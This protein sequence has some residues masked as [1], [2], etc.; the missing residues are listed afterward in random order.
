MTQ[1]ERDWEQGAF[2]RAYAAFRDAALTQ[3]DDLALQRRYAEVSE[4]LNQFEEARRVSE[5]LWARGEA[6]RALLQ[7]R[8]RLSEET[9]PALQRAE[10]LSWLEALPEGWEK[11]AL[12]A[13]V[14]FSTGDFAG[15][16]ELFVRLSQEAPPEE[17]AA[18]ALS[19]AMTF[20][21]S[22]DWAGGLAWL[23]TRAASQNLDGPLSLMEGTFL[24]LLDRT[25]ESLAEL[26]QAYE[27]FGDWDL[28]LRCVE[29]ALCA[30]RPDMAR[31]ALPS[32]AELAEREAPESEGPRSRLRL[33][34]AYLAAI[35]GQEEIL[36]ALLQAS[37]GEDAAA[38][39][40]RAFTRALLSLGEGSDAFAELEAAV[41]GLPGEPLPRFLLA[42]ELIATGF[43]EEASFQLRKMD[44]P[45]YRRWPQVV[46]ESARASY[47]LGQVRGAEEELA[48]LHAR[49]LFT[50]E[51]LLF[52]EALQRELGKTE[53]ATR[54]ARLIR[55][56]L[57]DTPEVR[58]Q[59]A[60]EAR[61]AGDAK[62][63]REALLAM[64]QEEEVPS[65][66][67]VRSLEALLA[68]GQ[69]PLVLATLQEDLGLP[70]TD[71]LLLQAAALEAEGNLAKAEERLTKAWQEDFG[72]ETASRLAGFWLRQ[73]KAQK[74][75]DLFRQA[76]EQD[77][78]A[79]WAQASLSRLQLDSGKGAEALAL[80]KE[81][82][83]S[84]E[85]SLEVASLLTEIHFRERLW[86]EAAGW[87]EEALQLE[88]R[89]NSNPALR[90]WLG[91]S[92][93]NQG[94]AEQA[95][96][97]LE[98][99]S[100]QAAKPAPILGVLALCEFRLG[101]FEQALETLDRVEAL[102]PGL[103]PSQRTLAIRCLL[104]SG[105]PGP[106]LSL[107]ET[108]GESLPIQDRVTL[109]AL[110]LE[111][112]GQVEASL[113]SL[114]THLAEVPGADFAR[115]LRVLVQA[116]SGDV[117]SAL[118]EAQES[119]LGWTEAEWNELARWAVEREAGSS[120]VAAFSQLTREQPESAA[121]WNNLAWLQLESGEYQPEKVFQAVAKAR[122]LAP[123]NPA[124]ANTW[125]RAL[126]EAERWSELRAHA[127]AW[128]RKEQSAP[129][130]PAYLGRTEEATGN[131]E[132]ALAHY[133]EVLR[134]AD[135]GFEDGIDVG[136]ARARLRALETAAALP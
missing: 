40:E 114:A 77:P 55:E 72:R 16:R 59:M 76:L 107:L 83:N 84:G 30:E 9:L 82:W 60:S 86:S 103:S 33:T 1:A 80:A 118:Q 54:T 109:R 93:L 41:Q 44:H 27:T 124:V 21:A 8:L 75:A 128:S 121:Y 5:I 85:Q 129:R 90:Y 13:E 64:V 56:Q 106:A 61:A 108:H 3:P 87:A 95:Q 127:Q 11:E 123:E 132:E 125:A 120:A 29:V 117:A 48:S 110:A 14:L 46:V 42:S 38:E 51:S 70:S 65:T 99:A 115:R 36:Q 31:Q 69:A 50:S 19:A 71:S 92:L 17:Q 37:Q 111:Q 49:G 58:F 113:E 81:L 6:D 102:T 25:E 67:R 10:A 98:R 2:Q 116:R 63:A 32:V 43:F 91:A 104:G 26:Q 66:W 18:F 119:Q 12:R 45:L 57:A 97:W 68:M 7:R 122:E 126:E 23:Q 39:S 73:E 34:K 100:K 130:W 52:A 47:G 78:R 105:R 131:T 28:L 22:E 133:R 96:A 53:E 94:E 134:L 24:A 15:S 4:D 62:A 20:S 79:N 101:R 136:A 74:A 88:T 89:T 135:L 112:Q 35:A